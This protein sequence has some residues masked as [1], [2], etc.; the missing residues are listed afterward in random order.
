VGKHK[1]RLVVGGRKRDLVIDIRSGQTVNEIVD[2]R[3]S[4]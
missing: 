4:K 2:L 1:V 3:K